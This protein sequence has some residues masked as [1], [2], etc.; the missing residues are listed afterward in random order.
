MI[1]KKT[2]GDLQ[3]DFLVPFVMTMS[4]VAVNFPSPLMEKIIEISWNT[5]CTVMLMMNRTADK[6][7]VLQ[8]TI[9]HMVTSFEDEKMKKEFETIEK[10]KTIAEK[11]KAANIFWSHHGEKL[12][13]RIN[14]ND[15]YLYTHKQDPELKEYWDYTT[16]LET[17]NDFVVKE[18]NIHKFTH[19]KKSIAL[20][21]G[22]AHFPRFFKGAFPGQLTTL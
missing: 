19:D 20:T 6:R 11:I 22:R 15:Y 7:Q 12:I 9:T 18:D 1:W 17:D 10:A 2:D 8:K 5:P 3:K 14:N 16:A 13:R 4:N 21:A